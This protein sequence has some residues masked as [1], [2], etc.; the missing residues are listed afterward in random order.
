MSTISANNLS[1]VYKN[2]YSTWRDDKALNAAKRQEYLR[3]NPD[4]IEDYD[5][6][7]AKVLLYTVGMM[8]KSLKE[9]SNKV[10]V[11]FE[12]AT[13]LGLGY[14]A[15]GG[16]TLGYLTT[17]LRFIKTSIEKIT[18]KH[19][20]SKNIIS[21]G[22]SLVGG[23]LGILAAYPAYSFLSSVESK[24]HR[25]RKFETMEKELQDPRIFVVLNEEQKKEFQQNLPELDKNPIKT[26]P[27]ENLSKEVK[28][29][30]KIY[31]ETVD[32]DKEQAL[33][34]E[35]YKKDKRLYEKE[36]NAKEIKDAKKDMV[37]LNILI[38]EINTKSQSYKE[39]M[40][41]VTDNLITA[42]FAL[43]SLFALCY[44]RITKKMNIKSASLPAG[45]GV[46]LLISST[47][48]ANWAQRRAS[49]VGR[50]KAIQ[51]MKQNP[52]QLVYISKRKTDTIEDNEIQVEEKQKTST[53]KFIKDFFKHNKEYT[54]WKKTN[55]YTGEDIAN[56]MKKIDISPEQLKDAKRLQNNLFKT[57]YKVDKNTQN[58]SS[59]IDVMSESVKYPMTLILGTLGSV[60][61]MKYLVNLR[62]AIKPAEIFNNSIKYIGTIALFTIPSLFIN[63]YFAK[64][65]KMGAR[66]SDMTT[67]QELEDYRFFADYSKYETKTNN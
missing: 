45:M 2:E 53:L 51:E 32:F 38:K 34:K 9:N 28:S 50:F 24:I 33:F 36:L 37:L 46:L 16:A 35:K 64:A 39:K 43:G 18:Q 26:T 6:Q 23:V 54:E 62:N 10:S 63:A 13:N 25:K 29:M 11:A 60:L 44:E 12:T 3:R 1:K 47:F 8:D 52:E 67:M 48:F 58:Y 49:H 22:I 4:A 42:S 31:E 66:I 20:K 56:A 14:A 21:M 40:Q 59:D 65:Q 17:K 27:K 19:P 5:L 41:K 7:R 55:T 30:K 57:L 61:S 15:V